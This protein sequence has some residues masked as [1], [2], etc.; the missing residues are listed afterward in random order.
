[1]NEMNQGRSGLMHRGGPGRV[2]T[3][4]CLALSR[5]LHLDVALVRIGFVLALLVSGGTALLAYLLMWFIMPPSALGRAPVQR[6]LGWARRV[7]APEEESR[8]E[9]RV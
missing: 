6:V 9:R 5:Q 7:S 3:G 1:M 8:W 4:V 2:L